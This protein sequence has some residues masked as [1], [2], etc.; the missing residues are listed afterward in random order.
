MEAWRRE[1]N[2]HRPHS[3]LGYL[4]PSEFARRYYQKEPGNRGQAT[5][6]Q[7]RK[8]LIVSGTKKWGHPRSN[9]NENMQLGGEGN[10]KTKSC[11]RERIE[12]TK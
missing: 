11:N 6:G 10:G 4:T 2:N 3:S 1:Y 7:G 9:I 8:S 12:K 5:S